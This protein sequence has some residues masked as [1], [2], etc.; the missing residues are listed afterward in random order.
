MDEI[1]SI[2][3]TGMIACIIFFTGILIGLLIAI[4]TKSYERDK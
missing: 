1:M 2:Y 4:F 3:E